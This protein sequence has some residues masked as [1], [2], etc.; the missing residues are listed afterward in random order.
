M[1]G[2][3]NTFVTL[4]RPGDVHPSGLLPDFLRGHL[5]SVSSLKDWNSSKLAPQVLQW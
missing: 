5:V 2:A 3:E 4:P 1:P